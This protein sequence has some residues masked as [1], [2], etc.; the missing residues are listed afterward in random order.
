MNRSQS[1]LTIRRATRDDVPTLVAMLAD[2]V[3]G[4]ERESTSI[5]VA[6]SYFE[7]FEAIDADE[8][9]EL[10]VAE[11]DG[12]AVGTLQLTYIPYLTFHGGWRAQIEAVRVTS[13]HRSEGL[14]H[15]LFAWAIERA[16]ERG[17]HLVQLT[18]D[19][20]RADAHRFYEDLGFVASHEGMKLWLELEPPAG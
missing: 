4:R 19:R 1:S 13:G 10:V 5:E 7:A 6:Q 2:D 3:L 17:C 20:R 18:T 16:R 11:I 8:H 9:Q 15:D 14:G 12:E